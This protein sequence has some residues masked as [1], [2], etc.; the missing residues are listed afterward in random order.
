MSAHIHA[1]LTE[2]FEA[3]L[4]NATQ[5]SRATHMERELSKVYKYI[6]ESWLEQV[7]VKFKFYTRRNEGVSYGAIHTGHQDIVQ[8]KPLARKYFKSGGQNDIEKWTRSARSVKYHDR[9]CCIHGSSMVSVKCLHRL[10][11][12]MS[13]IVVDA[14]SKRLEVFRMSQITSHATI[15]RLRSCSHHSGY[16]RKS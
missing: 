2:H 15:T 16:L 14:H 9:F 13:M 12:P 4:L 8:T 3:A 1:L 6:M 10:C 11:K 5:I 7:E